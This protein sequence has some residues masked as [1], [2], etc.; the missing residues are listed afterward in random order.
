MNIGE[1]AL[2]QLAG[3]VPNPVVVNDKPVRVLMEERRD[4]IISL[5]HKGHTNVMLADVLGVAVTCVRTHLRRVVGKELK[6]KAKANG[7]SEVTRRA[8]ALRAAR[9][10]QLKLT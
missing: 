9:R 3:E 8:S 2:R 5:I 7:L 6:A 1:Q 10:A 4:E